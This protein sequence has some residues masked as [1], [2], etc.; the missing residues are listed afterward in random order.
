MKLGLFAAIIIGTLEHGHWLVKAIGEAIG[1]F[2]RT[3]RR[4]RRGRQYYLVVDLQPPMATGQSLMVTSI[5]CI[6][7]VVN[8]N[9]RIFSP[10]DIEEPRKRKRQGDLNTNIP[11]QCY[12][13]RDST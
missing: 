9:E 4:G 10:L 5:V 3:C 8:E 2:E 6:T 13:K 12:C 7:R 11:A 1:C